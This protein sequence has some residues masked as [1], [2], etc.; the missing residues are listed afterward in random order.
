MRVPLDLDLMLDT[1]GQIKPQGWANLPASLKGSSSLE[2]LD[3][4]INESAKAGIAI[5]LDMHCLSDAGTNASPVF[6]DAKHTV[7]QTLQGWINMATR[8]KKFP[9]VFAADV[10][11]EPF[12][13]TW[14]M[15]QAT[16]MDAFAIKAAAAIHAISPHWLIF[17]EGAS[18]SPICNATIDGDTVVCGYGDNLLGVRDHPISLPTSSADKLV[19]SPHTY[20]PAE[21]KRPEFQNSEFPRNMPDVWDNHWGYI[22]QQDPS[23]TV[24]LGEWGGNL[25]GNDALWTSALVDYLLANGMA[26]NFYWCLNA[27][28]GTSGLLANDWTTVDQKKLDLLQKLVPH[29]TVFNFSMY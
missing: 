26:S 5:L 22:R 18:K 15:G 28:S 19:Y 6:F 27:D 17:V 16:D 10:F 24:V 29:P 4:I 8:Y 23:A 2:V 9:N 14:G 20:G 11:N 25:E 13:A 21:H 3:Y 7:E 12:G 1:T